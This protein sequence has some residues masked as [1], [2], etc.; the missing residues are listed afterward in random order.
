[1]KIQRDVAV[2]T[3]LGS[4]VSV[5]L[6]TPDG[7][8]PWPVIATMSP[9]GKDVHWPERYPLYAQADQEPHAVWET[10]SPEWWTTRGYAVVRADSPGT[11]KSPG[12]L[13]LLGPTEVG[14]FYDVIEWA[15]LQPW[16][17]GR[18]GS[19]GISWLAMLQ[20]LVAAQRP[21]HLAAIVPWEGASD[22]YREFGRHG[23]I[24]ANR[25][26]T[27][28]WEK[29]IAPQLF[30]ATAERVELFGEM[31]KR[32]FIDDWY[33]ERTAVLEN[34]EVPVLAVG[35][36]GSLHLHQRGIVEGFLRTGS[37]QR[38]LIITAGTHIG[39]FYEPWAKERQLRFL[40]RWLKGVANGAENDAPV[41][42]AVRVGHDVVWRDESAWPIARTR[43]RRL[44]L[45]AASGSMGDDPPLDEAGASYPA[46]D[47][48]LAFTFVAEREVE[49]TGPM[50][51]RL[52]MSS[53]GHDL[54]VFLH[55]H[56]VGRDG[57]IRVGVGPQ[58]AP[59]PLAMGWLRTSHRE[60]DAG[61][62]EPWRP[63]HRHAT[64]S[65]LIPGEPVALDVEIW[66]TSITLAAGERLILRV[67]ASDDDL[68]VISHDD[69]RDRGGLRSF[70]TT[71]HAGGRFDSFLLVPEIPPA[72]IC[73]STV[74]MDA[75]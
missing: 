70:I 38:Q 40:D 9:Y 17:T 24:L 27:L 26:L 11:G 12:T 69:P 34:I 19:L 1:M 51:A 62:S 73:P 60:L 44:H 52:W 30:D 56:V 13:D 66:P 3:R 14:G 32:E 64:P 18:V 33:R 20:W 7:D 22:A 45:D 42:L 23:G 61:R 58:G 63:V 67:R 16:S 28:W 57:A 37:S 8:G 15:G 2:P 31:Q 68:G 53:T 50:A 49:F 36:W 29:Q 74:G 35:N 55:F 10:P 54:D 75:S 4:E 6:F 48:E 59:I 21:P 72:E 71:L 46:N 25:F 41:R 65:S 39:P 43:W 5:N 47:G